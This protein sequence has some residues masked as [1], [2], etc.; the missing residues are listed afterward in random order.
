MCI[1]IYI[2]RDTELP[3]LVL[4][5]SPRFFLCL[6][7][8][9]SRR[10]QGPGPGSWAAQEAMA[11][12]WSLAVLGSVL[13]VQA[14]AMGALGPIPKRSQGSEGYRLSPT[15]ISRVSWGLVQSRGL[16][17]GVVCW[18]RVHPNFDATVICAQNRWVLNSYLESRLICQARLLL[19][20]N[21][22]LS[23]VLLFFLSCQLPNAPYI[24]SQVFTWPEEY[25]PLPLTGAC[26]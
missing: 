3:S 19:T 5:P 20:P 12:L 18:V 16:R 17:F 13:A 25:I 10:A 9:T 23:T 21:L 11:R 2:Y 7:S 14:G 15:R 6:A 1:Y 8:C 22:R 4:S 26:F 24:A